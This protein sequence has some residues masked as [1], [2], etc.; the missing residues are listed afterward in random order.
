MLLVDAQKIKLE[1]LL[2]ILGIQYASVWLR[3]NGCRSDDL[4]KHTG[5]K[6]ENGA[7]RLWLDSV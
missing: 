1:E 5:W 6:M 7:K 2:L 4:R 3:D